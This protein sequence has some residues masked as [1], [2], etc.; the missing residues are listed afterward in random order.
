MMKGRI[1]DQS[2]Y[3]FRRLHCFISGLLWNIRMV[4]MDVRVI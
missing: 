2:G 4:H 3:D 1:K